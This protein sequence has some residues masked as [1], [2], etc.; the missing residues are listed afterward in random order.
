MKIEN[1]V[2]RPFEVSY[3]SLAFNYRA[4]SRYQ[5]PMEIS[6]RIDQGPQVG[7]GG[8]GWTLIN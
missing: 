6:F 7:G 1:L 5:E 8:G 2:K 3:S 4:S